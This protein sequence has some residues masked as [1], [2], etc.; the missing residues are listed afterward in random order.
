MLKSL[1]EITVPPSTRPNSQIGKITATDPDQ[2]RAGEVFYELLTGKD[3]IRVERTTGI[4][5][6][7]TF[8]FQPIF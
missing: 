7:F 5:I 2:G 6:K 3:L 1:I 4:N 8:S